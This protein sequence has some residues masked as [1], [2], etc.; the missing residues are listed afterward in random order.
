VTAWAAPGEAPSHSV[1]QLIS[2]RTLDPELAALV[3]L[4][5]EG[6]VPIV[7]GAGPRLTG[8]S[9]LL[10]AFLDFLPPDIGTRRIAGRVEDFAWLPDPLA[11][12]WPGEDVADL[13]GRLEPTS[14]R[15]EGSDPEAA[16]SGRLAAPT[17]QVAP[18]EQTFLVC[19]ELSNHAPMYTWGLRARV[20]VRAL[21]LGY[22]L[23]T[24]MHIESLA[25]L[26]ALLTPPP[27]SLSEDEVRRLGVVIVLRRFAGDE[28]R[29]LA[30]H[31]LRPVERDGE[32]HL[33]RRPPIVLAT[34]DADRDEFDHF[35]WG[36][37]P[38][39]ALRTG[40][41]QAEFE[42]ELTL[43]SAFLRELVAAGRTSIPA[44]RA[45]LATYRGGGSAHTHSHPAEP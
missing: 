8:K 26:F 20:L 1:A 14:A 6:H 41:N 30:A 28:R 18:P 10:H 31:Y 24:T 27:V 17:R 15:G 33:Q 34:W 9:T 19:E 23:G 38:E 12:G 2:Q 42:R 3:W 36:A 45:A 13:I 44:F 25:D 43:R 11:L 39:L 7:V 29:V 4:L 35:G 16:T 40:R 5:L 32:G 37:A 21:Q 22:G